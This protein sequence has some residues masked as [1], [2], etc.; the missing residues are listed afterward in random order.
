MWSFAPNHRG[1]SGEG[2]AGDAAARR[3]ARLADEAVPF[4]PGGDA[5]AGTVPF[6]LAAAPVPGVAARTNRG[7][8]T[9]PCVLGI[10]TLDPFDCC[11]CKREGAGGGGAGGAGGG[12]VEVDAERYI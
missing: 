11:E 6:F 10:A 1:P 2:Y 12:V 3:A 9:G 4:P 5:G 8:E 7:G